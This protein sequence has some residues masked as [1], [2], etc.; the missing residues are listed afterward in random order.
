MEIGRMKAVSV[1]TLRRPDQRRGLGGARGGNFSLQTCNTPFTAENLVKRKERNKKGKK[2]GG[3]DVEFFS[4]SLSPLLAPSCQTRPFGSLSSFRSAN[5]RCHS[6][7]CSPP[8]PPP[9]LLPPPSPP[10]PP[11][12]S[13]S[14]YLSR[15]ISSLFCDTTPDS[16]LLN[17]K[18]EGKLFF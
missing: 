11:P 3:G 15:S 10:P 13:A 2:R 17:I 7:V 8:P 12:A 4:L 14:L 1:V 5:H 16:G 6:Y 9:P 18:K